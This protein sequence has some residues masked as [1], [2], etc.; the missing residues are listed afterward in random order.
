MEPTEANPA[1]ADSGRPSSVRRPRRPRAALIVAL[2]VAVAAAGIGGLAYASGRADTA[3]GTPAAN[4]GGHPVVTLYDANA[5]HPP[6][7]TATPGAPQPCNCEAHTQTRADPP[8]A[9]PVPS[10]LIVVSLSKQWLWAYQ[11]GQ[12]VFDTPV[13]TGRPGLET[14]TGTFD[15]QQKLW[16]IWFYSPWG[17]DSPNYYDPEHVDFAM[18]FLSGGYFIHDATWRHCFGPGTN[19]PHT[20]PDGTQETGSHGCVNVSYSAGAWLINWVRMGTTVRIEA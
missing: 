14:P 2:L 5:S 17:R 18:L 1:P 20:C 13:T 15:I 3:A 9:T 16:D 6:Q 4:K 10:Q 8:T 19:V 7:G 12:V 11:G